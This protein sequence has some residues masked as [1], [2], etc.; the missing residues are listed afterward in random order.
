MKLLDANNAFLKMNVSHL[1]V[2]QEDIFLGMLSR[3]SIEGLNETSLLENYIS[4][5]EPIFVRETAH[6]MEVLHVMQENS[7]NHIAVLNDLGTFIQVHHLKDVLEHLLSTPLISQKGNV[8][9]IAADATD[10]SLSQITQI[11]EAHQGT[12][13]GVLVENQDPSTVQICIKLQTPDFN[14][15]CLSLRRYGYE[16]LS[17]KAEKNGYSEFETQIDYLKKYIFN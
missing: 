3:D 10:F 11:V 1:P 5:L 9:V 17:S 2:V 14:N 6:W 13:L 12:I 16:I 7:C 4:H 8:L 15:T